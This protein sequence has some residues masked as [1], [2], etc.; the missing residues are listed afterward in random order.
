MLKSIRAS[1]SLDPR[2]IARVDSS[3]T[4]T[5]SGPRK[6]RE[7]DQAEDSRASQAQAM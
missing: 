6:C 1:M 2:S 5:D 7:L 3:P 4:P